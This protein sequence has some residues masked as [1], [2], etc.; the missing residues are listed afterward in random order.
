MDIHEFQPKKSFKNMVSLSPISLL[1][2]TFTKWKMPFLA[3]HLEKAVVKVQVHAGGRGKAGG[4]KLA[5]NKQEILDFSKQLLGMRLINSQT[6][7]EGVVAHQLLISPLID[8]RKR[9]LSS[10]Y[11]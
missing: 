2:L 8:F 1:S 5:K 11:N 3:V 10:R 7:K 4:V 6:G 9:V